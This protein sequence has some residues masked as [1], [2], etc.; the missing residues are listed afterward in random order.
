MDGLSVAGTRGKHVNILQHL[1]GFL[2]D[3]LTSEDKQEMLGP[4]RTTGR[5]W[6]R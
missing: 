2:K 3:H 6:C 1:M 4:S 5:G